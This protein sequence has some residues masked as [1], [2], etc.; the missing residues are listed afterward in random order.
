MVRAGSSTF[1]G[2]LCMQSLQNVLLP[3]NANWIDPVK[4]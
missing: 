4:F 1:A 3:K 2:F